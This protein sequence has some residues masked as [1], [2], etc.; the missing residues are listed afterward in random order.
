[1]IYQDFQKRL[2]EYKKSPT[3][4]EERLITWELLFEINAD[5]GHITDYLGDIALSLH[6]L[7]TKSD[8]K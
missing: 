3:P 8:T 4:V 5:L 6:T 2:E 7:A 1:M